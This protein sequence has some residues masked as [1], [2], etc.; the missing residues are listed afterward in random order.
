MNEYKITLLARK[1]KEQG[2]VVIIAW[3][4]QWKRTAKAER[5]SIV[6]EKGVKNKA[7]WDV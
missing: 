7:G 6:S 2:L 1:R 5:D 4:V 3:G